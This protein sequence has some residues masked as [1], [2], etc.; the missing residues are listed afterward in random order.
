MEFFGL[1]TPMS[2]ASMSAY[3]HRYY[4]VDS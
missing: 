4:S 2:Y 1:P 3:C